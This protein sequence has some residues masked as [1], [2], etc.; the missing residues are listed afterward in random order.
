MKDLFL[1]FTLI[2]IST[3]SYSQEPLKW[4]EVVRVD[5]VTNKN[6]LFNRA[7][8]W[9]S[10]TFNSEKDVISILDR[11]TGEISG[12]AVVE[13]KSN[14]FY[15]GV[16]CVNGYVSFKI[17]IY[18]KDGRYKYVIHSLI[19][20]G[21]YYNGSSPISYGILTDS[22]IAPKPTRGRANNKAWAEIKAQAANQIIS[23]IN[24]LKTEM[25]K[26]SEVQDD[27]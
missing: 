19:H 13:Y 11:N 4:E 16:A 23:L 9:F 15:M 20:E 25:T 8:Q 1:I 18:V 2:L 26:K 7:R 17:N 24:T 14:R 3:L 27:W 21:S 22:D 5:S 10:N 12:N 6:E